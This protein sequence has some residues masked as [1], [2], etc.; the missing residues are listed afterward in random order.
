MFTIQYQAVDGTHK[1]QDF[2]I[3][4]RI[5]LSIHLSTFS[6]PIVAVYENGSVITKAARREVALWTGSKSRYGREFAASCPG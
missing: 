4:S 5:K 6:R 1:M 3:K 2:D